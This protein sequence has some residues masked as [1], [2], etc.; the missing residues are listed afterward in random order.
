MVGVASTATPRERLAA[1]ID[2]AKI[3]PDIQSKLDH[4]RQL[5]EDLLQDDPVLLAE[6]L[7]L[8]L[9]LLSDPFSPVRRFIAR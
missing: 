3:S 9:D 4:L 7:P 6:F 2:Y 5:K 8:L 1:L